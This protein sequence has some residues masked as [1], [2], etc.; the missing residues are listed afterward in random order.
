MYSS[1]LQMSE[2]Q[3]AVEVPQ[4]KVSK[5]FKASGLTVA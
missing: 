1:M 2:T 3:S 5:D 4:D